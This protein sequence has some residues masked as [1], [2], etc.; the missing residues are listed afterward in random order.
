MREGRIF[1]SANRRKK[2]LLQ[3]SRSSQIC[4]QWCRERAYC[5]SEWIVVVSSD[6]TGFDDYECKTMHQN[7]DTTHCVTF[8]KQIVGELFQYK[9]TLQHFAIGIGRA[10]KYVNT[11][12]R[13]PRSPTL[14]TIEHE[15]D[16]ICHPITTV[17]D[18]TEQKGKIVDSSLQ[19]GI[20]HLYDRMQGKF[21]ACIQQNF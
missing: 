8:H 1:F 16:E 6:E 19:N 14:S 13:P 9:N 21:Q 10:L 7:A 18:L 4:L 15:W 17:A 12:P 2:I 20:R 3:T 11:L 5:K